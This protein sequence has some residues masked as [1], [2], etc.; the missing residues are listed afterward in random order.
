MARGVDSATLAWEMSN[1]MSSSAVQTI[2]AVAAPCGSC[3]LFHRANTACPVTSAL[4]ARGTGRDLAPGTVLGGRFEVLEVVHRSG[5][6]TIYRA[7]FRTD[8]IVTVAIKQASVAGLAP[9]EQEE[10]RRWMAREAGLLSSLHHPL[11]PDLIAAFSEGDEHYVVMPFIEGMTLKE[12]FAREGTPPYAEMV[13]WTRALTDLL[14]YLH[15]QDPPII[16]RDLKPDN[17]LIRP[18]NSLVVLDL[19]VARPLA[20]G[21]PGTAIGT[22]G[23]AA[24]E[25]YQGLADERSDLYALGAIVHYMLTGY[26]AEREAPFRH[27]SVRQINPKLS[28]RI[29]A[30]VSKLLC[31]APDERPQSATVLRDYL[32]VYAQYQLHFTT[33]ANYAWYKR[34]F[35]RLLLPMIIGSLAVAAIAG[36]NL[37]GAPWGLEAALGSWRGLET[38]MGSWPLSLVAG[39]CLGAALRA[40]WIPSL[41]ANSLRGAQVRQ[42]LSYPALFAVIALTII[43]AFALSRA[44]QWM[45]VP[46]LIL[47]PYA[48]ITAGCRIAEWRAR[49]GQQRLEAAMNARIS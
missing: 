1:A 27:P 16:H 29:E 23:Y 36:T 13:G 49:Q 46:A 2:E 34:R 15:G 10:A 35:L 41:A 4:S 26:D 25:Q 6:S 42:I 24:P 21:V 37:I 32:D 45:L 22:P 14:I 9:E 40:L 39:S 30:V 5:M 12:F 8:R 17:V 11:L 18:D 43:Y 7:R 28:P 48:V 47:L 33:I 20:R 44:V 3:G 19:G 31:L 38:G